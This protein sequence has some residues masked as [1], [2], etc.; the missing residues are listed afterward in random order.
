MSQIFKPTGVRQHLLLLALLGLAFSS[1]SFANNNDE[2]LA[3][4]DAIKIEVMQEGDPIKTY[5]D[6]KQANV[7][8]NNLA[9]K[10]IPQTIDTIDVS[11]YKLYGANDLSV[12][13]QGTPGVSTNYDMRGDG[14]AIRGFTA[15]SGDIYRDGIRES[16]QVRR[17]TANIERIEI[18]KGPASVLYGRSA[19]GGVINMVS[20]SANFDSTSSLGAYL[21][22]YENVGGT[23]DINK[24]ISDKV[25]VRLTGEKYDTNSFR[26]GIG[27]KQSMISPS[28]TYRNDNKTLNWTTQFL[29]DKLE[30]V[31]DR[32]P[33]YENMPS[34]VS[35]HMGFAQAGDYV[36]DES[37]VFRTDLKYEYLPNWKFHWALS[38]REASQNFDHFYLGQ[39][40]QTATTV[41]RNAGSC[42]NHV[43]DI[44]Q[45][46][47]WQKT[48]NKTT[49][50]T[51][52][53]T[54]EF[55]TGGIKHNLLVGADWVHEQREPRLANT[56][57]DGSQNG[58]RIVGYVNPYTGERSNTRTGGQL[59]LNTHNYNEGTS[60]GVFV[61][62]LISFSDKYKLMLGVRQDYYD[63]K[64]TNKRNGDH[65]SVK[66]HTF[67][68]NIGFV[69]QPLPTQSVYASY[70]R[71][72]APFGG[73]MG[74]N[75]VNSNTKLETFNFEPSYNDQYEI[76]VKSDWLNQRLN[77]QFSLFHIKKHNLRYLKD[78]NDPTSWASGA[79]IVSKGAEFS[80]IGRILDN[81]YMRGGYGYTDIEQ[82]K[83]PTNPDLIGKRP[84]N[85][86]KH[87]GNLFVR[88]LPTEQWYAELGATHVG[89]FY[90]N[91]E[92]TPNSKID[93]FTRFD[94]AVGFKNERWSIT[95]SG[96]N[97]TNK[98]YW[99]SGAMPGTP[100]NYLLRVNYL[101]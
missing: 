23:V 53:I 32:S 87:T 73:S 22:S 7:T 71:S 36:H 77:T 2:N 90:A 48:D 78:Q 37:K 27:A 1:H 54:G 70:S 80:V 41:V 86:S 24:V 52:D 29:Y 14:I 100:R 67:S 18:L 101:F 25:A 13:L 91:N 94:G 83:N 97:L 34:G 59:K 95:L 3:V 60:Y 10:D 99:R 21:G 55:F 51:F 58:K 11:K 76:G 42:N 47:Y 65:R 85:I 84:Q 56:Y 74:V 40:C 92:N 61:Q 39:Y 82:T 88:Y 89:D 66:E 17:S 93:G 20:K 79:E 63:F 8:R 57:E 31:P 33:N 49:S 15:D 98:N 50:N 72:F 43:G 69:W 64:T 46:Y 68:P 4:L 45:V 16:G 30:R 9:K 81:L 35:R 26:Q 5:V 62:D 12:M 38:H 75:V 44:S 96:N 6:Y 28:I 19:G